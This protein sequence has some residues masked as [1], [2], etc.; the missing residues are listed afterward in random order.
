MIDQL[1]KPLETLSSSWFERLESVLVSKCIANFSFKP[2][3]SDQIIQH[4]LHI[5][6]F[7]KKRAVEL[8]KRTRCFVDRVISGLEQKVSVNPFDSL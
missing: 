6:D 2:K 1:Q 3:C 4:P 5:N 8:E 7:A